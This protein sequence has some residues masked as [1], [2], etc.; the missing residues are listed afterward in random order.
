MCDAYAAWQ[1]QIARYID[2]LV[3]YAP[4]ILPTK[5]PQSSDGGYNEDEIEDLAK[6]CR[7]LWA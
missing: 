1:V 4:V 7:K 2:G 5:S 3:N 6:E